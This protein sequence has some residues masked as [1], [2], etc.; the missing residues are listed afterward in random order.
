M[1]PCWSIPPLVFLLSCSS[2][3]PPALPSLPIIA[4]P[5]KE[6]CTF[7]LKKKLIRGCHFFSLQYTWVIHEFCKVDLRVV[8]CLILATKNM[9]NK[10][11]KES[12]NTRNPRK[13]FQSKCKRA[14]HTEVFEVH[15]LHTIF[16]VLIQ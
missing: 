16:F 3:P 11:Y 7:S 15:F 1:R 6:F 13:A 8:L 14:T 4:K 5:F 12:K 9:R 10:K 2:P